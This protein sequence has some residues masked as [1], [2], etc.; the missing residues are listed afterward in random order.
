MRKCNNCNTTLSDSDKFCPD[1][2]MKTVEFAAGETEETNEQFH[3]PPVPKKQKSNKKKVITAVLLSALALLLIVG[4]VFALKFYYS[5]MLRFA[6]A[7][8]AFF[9]S[10]DRNSNVEAMLNGSYAPDFANIST[11]GSLSVVSVA[12]ADPDVEKLLKNITLNFNTDNADGSHIIGASIDYKGSSV[13][14]GTFTADKENVGFYLPELSKEYYLINNGRFAQFVAGITDGEKLEYK[15]VANLEKSFDRIKNRYKKILIKAFDSEDFEMTG[16]SVELNGISAK[17]KGCKRITFTPDEER[18]A[19]TIRAFG[20]EFAGDKKLSDHVLSLAIEYVGEDYANVLLS[21]LARYY[22]YEGLNRSEG[23]LPLFEKAGDELCANADKTARAIKEANFTWTVVTKKGKAIA[24]YISTDKGGIE[25]ERYDNKL[26]LAVKNED[27]LIA[28]VLV[29]LEEKAG[30]LYGTIIVDMPVEEA[31]LIVAVSDMDKTKKSAL[32]I[33]H[34]EYDIKADYP[35]S[36][37]G[38]Q[39]SFALSVKAGEEGGTDH[40]FTLDLG[41]STEMFGYELPQSITYNYHTT[42]RA[43]DIKTPD[44]TVTVVNSKA[45]IRN[46]GETLSSELMKVLSR[47]M[48]KLSIM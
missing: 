29:D 10:N 44:S 6:R 12:G 41:Q 18:V 15:S 34:G 27:G 4:A 40:I 26:Y 11:D 13:I 32:G 47:F 42:D 1:C 43:S 22:S 31:K 39:T 23:L 7:Q 46:I 5:P 14:S 3:I 2:G 45:Q 37:V 24:Q 21:L 17:V 36:Y 16:G 48:L 35:Y 19:D 30:L 8:K 25:F 28:S 38:E 33:N 9:V 20:K